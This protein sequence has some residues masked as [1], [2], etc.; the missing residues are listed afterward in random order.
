MQ[1]SIFAVGAPPGEDPRRPSCCSRAP[2]G[3]DPRRPSSE[4]L[5]KSPHARGTVGRAPVVP[6]PPM[7]VLPRQVISCLRSARC[8][9]PQT[10]ATQRQPQQSQHGAIRYKQR[11]KNHHH[12]YPDGRK[13]TLLKRTITYIISYQYHHSGSSKRTGSNHSD[14]S[15]TA[16]PTKHDRQ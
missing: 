1:Y 4:A 2:P 3:A 8:Q 16:P 12:I 9:A 5:R 15:H 14:F 10:P 6:V 7:L 13:N 11:N